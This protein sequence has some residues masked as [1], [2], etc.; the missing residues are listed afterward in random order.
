M[1]S[2]AFRK[3]LYLG[4]DKESLGLTEDFQ[5]VVLISR[6]SVAVLKIQGSS[7]ASELS[8]FEFA[9]KSND[10]N[11][12]ATVSSVLDSEDFLGTIKN[13][14]PA[15]WITDS[16]MTVVPQALYDP[17]KAP[18][19][20]KLLFEN[21]EELEVLSESLLTNELTLLTGIPKGIKNKLGQNPKNAVLPVL[22]QSFMQSSN[23]SNV[24]VIVENKRFLLIVITGTELKFCNW[25]SFEKAEDLLYFLMATLESLN[26]LHSE[27]KLQLSG[28]VEKGDAVYSCLSKFISKINFTTRPKSLSYSYS[29]SKAAEHRFPLLF[30]AACA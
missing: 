15:F 12:T 26:I 1:S 14:K 3:A 29:F 8:V 11:W 25:F 13:Q 19:N 7:N 6:D 27:V 28:E 5:P 20:I 30:A 17:E 22:D 10:E 4:P 2:S 23:A 24:S 18:D 16:R 9:Y 21:S